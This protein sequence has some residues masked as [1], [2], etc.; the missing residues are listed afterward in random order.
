MRINI[1]NI[2]KKFHNSILESNTILNNINLNIENGDILS[3]IGNNGAGKTTLLKI[4]ADRLSPDN[5]SI[6][7]DSLSTES[8]TIV[9]SNDRSFFWNLSIKQNLSFFCPGFDKNQKA[10]KLI[11]FFEL[12]EKMR[13]KYS[14]LSSGEKKKLMICRSIISGAKVL[15]LDEFTNSLDHITKITTYK[16]IKNLIKKNIVNIVIFVTHD[17]NEVCSLATRCVVIKNKSISKDIKI[18]RKVN[19]L[20]IKNLMEC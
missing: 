10:K 20:D 19:Y 12:K 1:K 5:G 16:L 18:D 13:N 3:I 7:Y 8:I 4:I 2:T 9:T 15:I 6:N 14:S 17:I 11:E